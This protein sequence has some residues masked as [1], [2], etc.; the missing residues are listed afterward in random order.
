MSEH[1]ITLTSDERDYLQSVLEYRLGVTRVEF[2]HTRM[3]EYRDVVQSEEQTIR[4]LLAKLGRS[5]SPPEENG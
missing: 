1:S 4:D 5:E 3:P 2:R